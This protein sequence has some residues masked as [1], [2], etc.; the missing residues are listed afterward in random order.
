MEPKVPLYH[1]VY[2]YLLERIREEFKPGDLLPTQAE[3]ARETDTSLITV[4]RAIKELEVAGLIESRAGKGTT[5]KKPRI[6]DSHIGVSSWTDS[7]VGQGKIPSTAWTR[8]EKRD[9][10]STTINSLKL[11]TR[12][13]T[14]K[15]E[16]LRLIDGEP[17]CLMS[18]ELPVHLVPEFQVDTDIKESIYTYLKNTY[19]LT[20]VMADEEVYARQATAYEIETLHLKSPIV[21]VIERV[22]YLANETPFEASSIIAAAESYVYRSKQINKAADTQ[23]L[24]HLLAETI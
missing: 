17:I 11:K 16:R 7:I 3:I 9:P 21:L 24:Q 1:K 10:T 13:K 5:V 14:I 2:H 19:N 4:K 6:I 23:V 15:I 12:Q 18:N 22:S 8:I 20:G